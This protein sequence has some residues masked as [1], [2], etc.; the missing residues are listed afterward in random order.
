[1]RL[2]SL[3]LQTARGLLLSITSGHRQC[4]AACTPCCVRA[5]V[6]READL[7]PR[8]LDGPGAHVVFCKKGPSRP[9]GVQVVMGVLGRCSGTQAFPMF[10]RSW[11]PRWRGLTP[12]GSH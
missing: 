7:R 12:N 5:F 6:L 2:P 11:H 4:S 8:T 10:A 9:A 3:Q 1:M